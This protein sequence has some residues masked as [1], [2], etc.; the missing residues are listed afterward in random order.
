MHQPVDL[1]EIE[2]CKLPQTKWEVYRDFRIKALDS[3]PIAFGSSSEEE[4]HFSDR[5]WKD[6]IRN[7]VFSMHQ[8]N[9][10][11]MI[12]FAVRERKKQ[13]HVADIFSFFVLKEYRG[14]G[15]GNKLLDAAIE[16]IT[17]TGGITKIGLSVNTV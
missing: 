17:L 13:H 15:I 11:G 4:L 2:I 12:G 8:E 3:D 6:R 7:I 1:K 10:V 5:I 16:T 9:P 14:N